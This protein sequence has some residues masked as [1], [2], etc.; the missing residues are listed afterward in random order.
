MNNIKTTFGLR[1]DFVQYMRGNGHKFLKPSKVFLESDKSL[2]FVNSG[3][4]QLKDVFLGKKE[5]DEKFSKLT[6]CQISI[7]A[8]G[9]KCDLD[10]V[11]K[12]Q[13]HLSN[14]GMCGFWSLNNYWK[15]EAITLSYNYLIKCGLDRNRM[16]A[17]YFE[18]NDKVPADIESKNIWM[19]FL[20]ESNIVPGSFKDNY[21]MMG[22]DGVSGPCT[23]IHYDIIESRYNA[24]ELVNKDD[25]TVIELWNIVMM[26]YN[27]VLNGEDMVFEPL[28]KRFIDCGWGLERIAMVLQNKTSIY[29][30]D[31]F[32]KL[33][34][35]VEIMSNDKTYTD[36]YGQNCEKDVAI[37]IFSDHIRT[38]TIAL[39][40]GAIFDCN[41]RGFVLRKV[42]RRL[43]TNYYLHLNDCVVKSVMSHHVIE[44]LISEILNFHMFY[45]HNSSDIKKL[46]VEE[47]QMFIGRLNK[48]KMLYESK[49]K[50]AIKL[51]ER[52][53]TELSKDEISDKIIQEFRQDIDKLKETHGVD[54]CVVENVERLKFE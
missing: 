17:T 13:Y 23:E 44:A 24:S 33:I 5:F 54:L 25:P 14:F 8:G 22:V 27:V 45:T 16:Y 31:I 51:S 43:L 34:K 52:T 53:G 7:R 42:I 12:D 40:D 29:Q 1:E 15:R 37:R 32:R 10:E 39:Y 35:Y 20:D 30:T 36:I 38:L 4:V 26:Q 47:E 6:N 28:D 3:M 41:G 50:K 19:E 9:K 48:F 46:L 2:F 11:G 49:L 18:G 21:W